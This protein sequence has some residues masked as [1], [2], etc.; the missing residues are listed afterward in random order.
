M[1]EIQQYSTPELV[2]FE[3]DGTMN[4]RCVDK[5]KGKPET[6]FFDKICVRKW[7]PV[8]DFQ[9]TKLALEAFTKEVRILRIA[10]H[11]HVIKLITEYYVVDRDFVIIMDRAEKDMSE[12]LQSEVD[13]DERERF[14][15]WS[16]CLAR[17]MDHLHRIGIRHRDLKPENILIKGGRVLLTDFGISAIGLKMTISTTLQGRDSSKTERYA[18]PEVLDGG[19]RDS[20]ADIFSLG[21]VFLEML[22]SHS[23]WDH[24]SKLTEAI[25]GKSPAFG[26]KL[27][28]VQEHIKFLLES[29]SGD[30]WVI[31]VL[32]LCQRML[33]EDSF[34]RPAAA[35]VLKLLE[36]SSSTDCPC[37]K[38]SA[39]DLL[40]ESCR[41]HDIDKV[42]ERLH[43]GT[44]P[45]TV[46]AIHQAASREGSSFVEALLNKTKVHERLKLVNQRNYSGQT[47]LLCA[48]GYGD[49]D[50]VEYLIKEGADITSSDDD[51]HTALH[52]AAG[53]GNKQVVEF[54]LK[55]IPK[56][57]VKALLDL[58]DRSGR[59]SLLCAVR[60]GHYGAAQSLLESGADVGLGDE[61]K[62]MPLHFAAR[63]G[64]IE[65]VNLLLAKGAMPAGL[66]AKDSEERTPL[67]YAASGMRLEG[68]FVQVIKRLLELGAKVE[69]TDIGAAA[70]TRKKDGRLKLLYQAADDSM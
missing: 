7:I 70:E 57:H 10:Q 19:S 56:Q 65:T 43:S 21:A 29:S 2:P 32:E 6:P 31:K 23:Y 46:G 62:R 41:K 66:H 58:K 50:T 34:K 28:K 55:K 33:D 30:G 42:K 54:L 48:V 11:Y 38:L 27:R 20:Q 39:S 25:K 52:C 12:L 3:H 44:D 69:E 67:Y 1:S 36:E 61:K 4:A 64:C 47:P 40:V 13:E 8:K 49:I 35:E 60:R 18:A 24:R 16:T 5:V 15:S 51:G 9:D 17:A 53:Y 63:Y 68:K 59:T 26:T 22:H 37:N 14:A 45:R